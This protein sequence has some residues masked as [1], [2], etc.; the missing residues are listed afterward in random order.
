[1]HLNIR[2]WKI[3]CSEESVSFSLSI[4]S[5]PQLTS[6]LSWFTPTVHMA[7]RGQIYSLESQV[8]A[9]SVP[10]FCVA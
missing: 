8:F 1:M 2:Q 6:S 4:G 7:D 5:V 9:V 3:H 10:L